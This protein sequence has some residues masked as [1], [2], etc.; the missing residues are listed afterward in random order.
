M[1]KSLFVGRNKNKIVSMQ[2]FRNY[3][4]PISFLNNINNK[5]PKAYNTAE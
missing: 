3:V 2:D 5:L 4:N 1:V